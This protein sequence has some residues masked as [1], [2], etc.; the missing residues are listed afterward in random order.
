[1]L[2]SVA[3]LAAVCLLLPESRPDVRHGMHSGARSATPIMKTPPPRSISP[4]Q[5]AGLAAF[6][7]TAGPLVDAVHNQALL[8]YKIMPVSI[9]PLNA[10]TS[11]LIPPL[12]GVA[13]VLLGSVLPAVS[14]RLVGSGCLTRNHARH[15]ESD[16]T[17]ARGKTAA[18]AVLST[19]AI[20]KASELLVLSSLPVG[21]CL[22]LL[23]AACCCQWIALDG[24]FA[25][26]A[27]ALTAAVG[28]PLAELP[29]MALGCWS[30]NA[31]DYFPLVPFLGDD[32]G[33]FGAAGSTW[34]GLNLITAPCYF[35]VTTDAIAL[36]RW[37]AG[38][39]SGAV[40]SDTDR[41]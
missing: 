12:L 14:E 21:A 9:A 4:R 37:F 29:L 5:V 38:L 34:A 35:A 31:P 39:G 30:Y 2:P 41:E 11:L 36:G 33:P 20:I 18:V 40:A 19:I 27:L 15:S 32:F 28:G 8:T 23:L 3:A 1:M 13:Y 7:A 26:L 10:E 25:S 16:N 22:A 6:G 24:S 17:S